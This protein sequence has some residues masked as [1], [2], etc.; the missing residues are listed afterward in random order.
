MRDKLK[1]HLEINRTLFLGGGGILGMVVF[2]FVSTSVISLSD[3]MGAQK[4]FGIWQLLHIIATASPAA[5]RYSQNQHLAELLGR[6]MV[7]VVF[8]C[9]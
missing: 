9:E 4:L 5:E 3:N 8:S 6:K 1:S 2:M 7:V